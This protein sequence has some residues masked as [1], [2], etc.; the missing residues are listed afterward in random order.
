MTVDITV[1]TLGE[2]EMKEAAGLVAR[3]FLDNPLTYELLGNDPGK[4]LGGMERLNRGALPL[5]QRRPICARRGETVVGVLGIAPPGTCILSNGRALGVL[6]RVLPLGLTALGRLSA[7]EREV[8]GHDPTTAHWHIGPV[9]VEP[10]LQGTG[11]GSL[12][13]R[14]L[15]AE[16]D[17]EGV[18]AHLETDKEENVRLYERFGFGVTAR[19]RFGT[20]P[21]WFMDRPGAEE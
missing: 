15:C 3:A 13:L 4:R 5:L 9:A 21:L 17:E 1:G 16:L 20:C 12:M 8:L 7:F 6:W 2:P 14:R 19:D 11:I 10:A 18:A